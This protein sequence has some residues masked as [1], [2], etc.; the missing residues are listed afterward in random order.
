MLAARGSVPRRREKHPSRPHPR[1]SLS[2]RDKHA[3][4]LGAIPPCSPKGGG[5]GGARHGVAEGEEFI[6]AGYSGLFCCPDRGGNR[7]RAKP[8]RLPPPRRRA[9]FRHFVCPAYFPA[10]AA[11][12]RPRSSFAHSRSLN[13]W[14]F[15]EAVWGKWSTTKKWA[16]VL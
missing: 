1:E 2:R 15:P 8:V 4:A 13:F 16:G 9:P 12:A 7:K 11:G 10:G 5:K 14:I 6:H 3:S